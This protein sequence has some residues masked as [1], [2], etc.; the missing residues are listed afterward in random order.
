MLPAPTRN[1]AAWRHP[2][3]LLLIG[4][5]GFLFG[6]GLLFAGSGRTARS[7]EFVGTTGFAV[8]AAAIGAQT[9]Y[10][11]VIAGPLWADLAAVWRR[12]RTGRAATLALAGAIA[13]IVIGIRFVAG[14]C[15]PLRSRSAR[16]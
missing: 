2:V 6:V 14:G 1:P 10:W 7:E 4:I 9:A 13:V 12:A 8:W 3:W 11:A 16:R 5:G 15:R